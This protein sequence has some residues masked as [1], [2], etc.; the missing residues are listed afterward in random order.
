MDGFWKGCS[1][2]L[3]PF[4]LELQ[5]GL[6]GCVLERAPCLCQVQLSAFL[7]RALG[8]ESKLGLEGL[9]SWP[10]ALHVGSS[11]SLFALSARGLLE[12]FAELPRR[13]QGPPG[14]TRLVP[15]G[16]HVEV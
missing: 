3:A 8:L 16:Y 11:F 5:T 13:L 1:L 4:D 14:A 10:A 2:A 9:E 15:L 12:L 7:L 6:P